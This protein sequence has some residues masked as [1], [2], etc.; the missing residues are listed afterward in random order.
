MASHL[1]EELRIW[2]E[3][4]NKKSSPCCRQ[5]EDCL[6][7]GGALIFTVLITALLLV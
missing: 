5:L 1:A 3:K 2:Q 6:L 7:E 4:I